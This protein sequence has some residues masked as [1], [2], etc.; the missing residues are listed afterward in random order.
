MTITVYKNDL[1]DDL[2][3]GNSVAIDTEAMGLRYGR[4][5]LC[6]VQISN[7][8]GN[9]HLVQFSKGN[10]DAPNLKRLLT[11]PDIEKIFHFARFD[12]AIM[13][14][15]LG[16]GC[17]NVYCT[18]IASKLARTYTDRH[19]LRHLC[20]ELL[21]VDLNKQSQSS[22]W[23]AEELTNEQMN[24]AANDVYYLHKLK[25]HLNIMLEREGRDQLAKQ[26]FAFL[27]TRADLDVSGWEYDIFEH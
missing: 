9:A 1:P 13:K 15:F 21:S 14:K 17:P 20:R 24:Y 22:D 2:D 11:N 16:V 19:S 27:G 3:L 10:Y 26:C 12:V 6:L 4:D 8:D 5:R 25:R 7:G 18:K 23:G